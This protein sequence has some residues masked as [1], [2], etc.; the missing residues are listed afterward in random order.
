[1]RNTRQFMNGMKNYLTGTT[2]GETEKLRQEIKKQTE[3]L[4]ESEF[5]NIDSI[6]EEVLIDLI[7]SP[8]YAYI[9]DLLNST[10]TDLTLATRDQK[11]PDFQNTYDH[12]REAYSP[13]V[14]LQK[15]SEFVTKV[16]SSIAQREYFY[17]LL[18]LDV[19]DLMTVLI[20][21][22]ILF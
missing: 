1:M 22:E 16:S 19:T 15:W 7:L 10:N 8:L 9:M 14:K 11:N 18:S 5:L 21:N 13:L 3:L 2:S 20:E 12:F 4:D 17:S 6:L